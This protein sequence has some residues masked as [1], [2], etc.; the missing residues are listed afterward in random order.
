MTLLKNNSIKNIEDEDVVV[1]IIEGYKVARN[2]G[3]K[4][5]LDCLSGLVDTLL[6][7]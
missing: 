2:Y 4:D 3:D 1:D 7:K 5:I 6:H